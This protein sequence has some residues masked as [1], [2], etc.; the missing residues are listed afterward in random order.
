[1]VVW[2]IYYR[3]AAAEAGGKLGVR[4]VTKPRPVMALPREGLGRE[5]GGKT[6]GLRVGRNAGRRRGD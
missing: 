2:R 3:E 5:G 1:M 6:T 4:A